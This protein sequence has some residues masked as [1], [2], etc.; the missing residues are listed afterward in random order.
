MYS[1]AHQVSRIHDEDNLLKNQLIV[2]E[3]NEKGEEYVRLRFPIVDKQWNPKNAS[4]L[5][6]FASLMNIIRH[7]ML[8]RSKYEVEKKNIHSDRNIGSEKSI[9]RIKSK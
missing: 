6:T 7:P 3:K 1:C 5:Q 2:F 8:I 4:L 9:Q